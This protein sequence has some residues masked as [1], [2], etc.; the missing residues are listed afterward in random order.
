MKRFLSSLFI[1]SYLCILMYGVVC[2]TLTTGV[3]QHPGMYFVVWDMFCGWDSY[4]NKFHVVGEGES[5]KYYELAPG[6]WGEIHPYGNL[7]RQHYDSHL[8]HVHRLAL[9]T[10]KHTSHE[11]ILKFY[12]IE[13]LWSKKYDFPEYLW[14][15]KYEAPREPL[16]YF[17]T[18]LV[19]DG[20]GVLVH[21]NSSWFDNQV[22]RTINTPRI[23]A[24]MRSNRPS[25]VIQGPSLPRETS[26]Q[27]LS[28]SGN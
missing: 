27:G 8:A 17:N 7:G 9:N 14:K 23:M 5:G 26:S 4:A 6:P 2:H 3:A 22:S 12:V 21:K 16:S 10:L 19:Y 25:M 11:P 15:R 24:D 20:E 13:E 18:R 28:V 1:C